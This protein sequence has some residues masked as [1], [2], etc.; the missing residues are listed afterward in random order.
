[1]KVPALAGRGALSPRLLDAREVDPRLLELPAGSV[2]GGVGGWGG[3]KT[4]IRGT[5]I[6]SIL[7]HINLM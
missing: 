1:M 4:L 7:K 3:L 6:I 5:R 2:G